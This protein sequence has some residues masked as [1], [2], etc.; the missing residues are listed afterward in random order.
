M[1]TAFG[2]GVEVGLPVLLTLWSWTLP[3]LSVHGVWMF[4][5]AASGAL[6]F[7]LWLERTFY[8]R[9]PRPPAPV[10][11]GTCLLMLNLYY[12]ATQLSRQFLSGV[13]L[14]FAF[15]ARRPLAK[16]AFVALATSFHLSAIP[17]FMLYVLV[18][19]GRIGWLAII[20]FALVMRLYFFDLLVALDV[21]PAAI[22][23]KLTYY[24]EEGD[25]FSAED[26]ISLRTMAVLAL[27]SVVA[28]VA[29]PADARAHRRERGSQHPGTP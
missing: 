2:G 26:L 24:S 19:R 17:F 6:V 9:L 10:L 21:L 25:L 16:L 11:L 20:L 5:L 4:C 22:A 13:V 1:L 8:G 15:S 14:L 28:I 12:L 18:K 27:V 23:E 3:A 7:M 29:S